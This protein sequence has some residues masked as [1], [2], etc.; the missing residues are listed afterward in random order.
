MIT[1]IR[2]INVTIEL[3]INTKLPYMCKLRPLGWV[4]LNFLLCI[5]G[6]VGLG[7]RFDGLG[8]VG[9]RNVD[10]LPSLK[11]T[12]LKHRIATEMR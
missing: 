12:P 2:V 8:W 5:M 11:Q 10:P 4:G 3:T 7:Q 9:L 1:N 6:W